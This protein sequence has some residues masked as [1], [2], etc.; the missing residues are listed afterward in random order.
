[1]SKL[2]RRARATRPSRLFVSSSRAIKFKCILQTWHEVEQERCY[3]IQRWAECYI[4]TG[5]SEN[6]DN[7][8]GDAPAFSRQVVRE[9]MRTVDER[10]QHYRFLGQFC[11]QKFRK[12]VTTYSQRVRAIRARGVSGRP[13]ATRIVNKTFCFPRPNPFIV[14]FRY[15]AVTATRTIGINVSVSATVLR[16]GGEKKLSSR[17]RTLQV[18]FDEFE[19]LTET[20][21]PQSSG[22]FRSSRGLFAS[23]SNSPETIRK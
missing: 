6:G 16:S 13:N 10:R 7:S 5:V 17:N 15:L 2:R 12:I 22:R 19:S 9:A 11:E 1:M 14:R 20:F 23:L 4:G 21:T 8:V 18:S 3:G